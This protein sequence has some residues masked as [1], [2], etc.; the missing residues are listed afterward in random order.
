MGSGPSYSVVIDSHTAD[1]DWRFLHLGYLSPFLD[2]KQ[3]GAGDPVAALS[4]SSSL[5]QS[6]NVLVDERGQEKIMC[7]LLRFYVFC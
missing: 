2:Q 4:S 7:N 5:T 6:I 1:S 3:A